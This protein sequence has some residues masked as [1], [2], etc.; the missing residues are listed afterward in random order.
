M[1][2][3]L[4]NEEIVAIEREHQAV[5]VSASQVVSLF[6]GRGVRLSEGTFRKYVQVG[7]LP[8][9]RR[10][11]RKGKNQGSRG[12]Y[13]TNVVRRVNAIK[14]MMAEGMTLE[15]IRGS[16]L[17]LRGELDVAEE[18]LDSIGEELAKALASADVPDSERGPLGE[19]LDGVKA[20]SVRLTARLERLA[21]RIVAA[22]DTGSEP[23]QN[24]VA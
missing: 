7:L 15:E 8:R 5:G 1:S 3:L 2:A 21:S 22:R 17:F 12:V 18:A 9:S 19:E 6:Q 4:S 23:N 10:V 11:G 20:D 16:F 24:G 13:P 14:A